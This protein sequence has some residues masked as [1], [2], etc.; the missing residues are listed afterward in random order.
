MVQRCDDC[1]H[2]VFIPDP[3]C[4][5]CQSNALTW[6]ES[7]GKGTVDSCT[8]VYRPQQ[9]AF[10]VPYVIAIVEVEEGWYI[11]TNIV[12]TEPENVTIGMPVQVKFDVRAGGFAVPVFVPA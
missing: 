4:S 9:P 2:Y 11:P 12:D 10:P 3:M 5:Q 7:S 6:V 8:T 1:G